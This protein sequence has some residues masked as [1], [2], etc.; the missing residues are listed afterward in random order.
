MSS[1][2]NRL[3]LLAFIPLLANCQTYDSHEARRAQS[4][5]VGLSQDELHM[6]AGLPTKSETRGP[7]TYDTYE[8]AAATSS[9][10]FS[11][12]LPLIGSLS[13]GASGYCHTTFRIVNGKVTE[14]AYAGDTGDIFGHVANCSQLVDHCLDQEAEALGRP[15]SQPAAAGTAKP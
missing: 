1:L 12:S 2:S 9:S 5:L 13:F 8:Q 11:A 14:V 10:D 15:V 3:L 4:E 6:C 7:A